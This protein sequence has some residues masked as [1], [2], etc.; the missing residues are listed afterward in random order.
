M[1]DP[2]IQELLEN[3][4][5]RKVL[6]RYCHAC[7]R[8]D[9]DLL[10]SCYWP[11]AGDDHGTYSGSAAGFVDFVIPVLRT[12]YEGTTH[13]LGQSTMRIEGD[14]AA[15]ETY[16]IATHK[17]AGVTPSA[18][19]RVGG[20]YVDRFEKRGGEWRIADRTLLIDWTQNQPDGE[21]PP[22]ARAMTVDTFR[23]GRRDGTDMATALIY[24]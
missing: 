12:A 2:A 22:G 3:F 6:E 14:R 19:N 11:E 13:Q 10:E 24:R 20:R 4:A 1:T 23:C 9:R 5:I 7:D 17:L 15:V 18:I 8:I 16:V 21:V